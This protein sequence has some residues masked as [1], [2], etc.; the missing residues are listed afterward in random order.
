MS[1]SN[2]PYIS[3]PWNADNLPLLS[4]DL[5]PIEEAIDALAEDIVAINESLA[6]KLETSD[7]LSEIS[8]Q[9]TIRSGGPPASTDSYPRND[10]SGSFVWN[11]FDPYVAF[12]DGVLVLTEDGQV[13]IAE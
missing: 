3:Y 1:G 4:D 2:V 12:E 10:G 8:R 9:V 11:D 6:L 5:T 7:L 13:E